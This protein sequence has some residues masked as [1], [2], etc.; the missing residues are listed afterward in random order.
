MSNITSITADDVNKTFD[1]DL[2][3]RVTS[4]D[5]NATDYQRFTYDANG[6]RLTLRG[7]TSD[8]NASA[9]LSAGLTPSV[10]YRYT[11]NT[12]ILEGV[13]Y[14]HRVDENTTQTE[15]EIQYTYDSIGNIINDGTHTYT[16]DSRN[17]LIAVDDNITY[18]YNYDNRRV[19]KTINNQTTYYIYEAH[20]LIGEY[21]EDGTTI[22]EYLY[23]KNTPIAIITP[24]ETYKIYADH[25]DTPRRVADNTNT[26]VWEW[27][28][29]PFGEDKP[30][31]ILALN[32]RFPGQYFDTETNKHYNIN[33]D[34]DPVTGRYVQSDPIGLE[35]GVNTYVYG[36]AT[37][38]IKMDKNGLAAVY[39]EYIEYQVY[40]G[41]NWS[42][43]SAITAPLGHAAVIA[44]DEKT[45]YTKYYEYGRYDKENRGIVLR[46]GVPNVT[47]KD[48]VPTE[49][50]LQNLYSNASKNWAKG[51]PT[52]TIYYDSA[53]Y[54]DVVA[55]AERVKA[56][57]NRSDYMLYFNDCMSFAN[58]AID[59][60]LP[61]YYTSW[62]W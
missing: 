42:D 54:N 26:I 19:S 25:L 43:G 45:G 55:Y 31:G 58:D 61:F 7:L 33:R 60:G 2:V 18:Q 50:S 15:K 9:L 3:D 52:F 16:Y 30:T 39:I 41:F 13:K 56:D 21:Q 38:L 24:T 57:P 49:E 62:G 34:Y 40:T 23:H 28:S 17:R 27:E 10:A 36:D 35:G 20:K 6:N 29:K 37:P 51:S 48:G 53:D 11:D 14:Y 46:R 22:K 44:I 1:Y 5:S 32:L 8:N 12:N 4:Y 47:I 59:A